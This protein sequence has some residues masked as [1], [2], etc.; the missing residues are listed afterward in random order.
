MEIFL[1]HNLFPCTTELPITVKRRPVFTECHEVHTAQLPGKFLHM[2]KSHKLFIGL[3]G[4]DQS[5]SSQQQKNHQFYCATWTINNAL[6]ALKAAMPNQIMT[7]SWQD[8]DR[9]KYKDKCKI[10]NSIRKLQDGIHGSIQSFTSKTHTKILDHRPVH[11][12]TPA[13]EFSAK[14]TPAQSC[15][16]KLRCVGQ[17]L[18]S[19]NH[20]ATTQLTGSA[21]CI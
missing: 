8:R 10:F 16:N 14:C 18:W 1:D 21:K 4:N 5:G 2:Y 3:F 17:H 20:M 19:V 13:I 12:K 11:Y 6:F 7:S 9:E 15:T